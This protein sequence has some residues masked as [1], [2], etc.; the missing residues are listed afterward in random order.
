MR[1]LILGGSG[2]LGAPAARAFAARGHD[3]DVLTRGTRPL[4]AGVHALVAERADAGALNAA[5][6]GRHYDVALDLLAYDDADV[7][8][9]FAVPGL[10]LGRYLVISSGQVYLVARERRPPFREPDAELPPMPEPPAGTRDHRNWVYGV[11]KRAVERST[12]ACSARH[13][14]EATVLRLPVVQGAHD[15]S[16]RLWAYLQRLL[17]GGPLLLPA[18]GEHPVRFVWAEDVARAAVALAEGAPAR[19]DAYNLAMHDEPTLRALLERAAAELG[20]MPRFVPCTWAD[21][22]AA[23]LAH[24]LSPYSGPWCSRPDPAL[25]AAEWGFEGTPS[26][27]W[28]PPVVR[29]HLAEAEPRVAHAD[30]DRRPAELELAARLASG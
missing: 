24:T 21:L 22:D 11:G 19:A 13:G 30:Y 8:R 5:L 20:V 1:V 4:P 3:V 17:D 10:R 29:A 26:A 27:G 2:L 15:G 16:R 7:E 25:A 9:L 18:G 28:L 23:A 12:R 6:G 14:V